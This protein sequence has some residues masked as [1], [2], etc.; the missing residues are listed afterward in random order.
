VPCSGGYTPLNKQPFLANTF[1][2]RAWHS[3]TTSRFGLAS[4]GVS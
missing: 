4:G 1:A 2:T 3:A